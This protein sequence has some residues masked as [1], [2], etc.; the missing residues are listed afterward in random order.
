MGTHRDMA[1]QLILDLLPAAASTAET[2]FVTPANAAAQEAVMGDAA[3]P[4]GKLVLIGPEG[5]GKSHLAGLWAA[6]EAAVILSGSDL[7]GLDLPP[8]SSACVVEDLDRLPH[9]SEE[10]LFHLFNHFSAIGGRLLMT[11]RQAPAQLPIEL[12]DLASRLQATAIADLRDPDDRLLA[13]LL[14]RF[15]ADRQ[16]LPTAGVIP[17][18]VG[19]MERSTAAA[20]DIV[21]DLDAAALSTGRGVTRD[22]ARAVL[23]NRTGAAR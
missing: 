19:R 12:P 2:F 1:R 5:A 14:A 15:M 10:P 9:G 18:L 4:Q 8:P 23:D 7:P 22:L 20:R 17:Y 21:A 13:L 16:I 3:W 6:R 11:A